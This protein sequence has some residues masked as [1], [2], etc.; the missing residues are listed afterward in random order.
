MM[1]LINK[2][3]NITW[4]IIFVLWICNWLLIA[5][6]PAISEKTALYMTYP[7]F[8]I[9]AIATIYVLLRKNRNILWLVIPISV[10]FLSNLEHRKDTANNE[11]HTHKPTESDSES[12]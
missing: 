10:L 8:T 1:S 2:H 6:V 7:I 9:W 5:F 11:H 4:T 3:L 12:V